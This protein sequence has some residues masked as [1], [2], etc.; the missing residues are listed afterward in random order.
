MSHRRLGG[1]QTILWYQP[2]CVMLNTRSGGRQTGVNSIKESTR[3]PAQAAHEINRYILTE[4]HHR[5]TP[6]IGQLSDHRM[7]PADMYDA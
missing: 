3:G 5:V 6:S 1:Y 7:I 2:T 4:A